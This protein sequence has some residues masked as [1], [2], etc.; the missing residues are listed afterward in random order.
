MNVP[1]KNWLEWLVFFI[2][3]GLVGATLSYLA[4]DALT[5]GDAP[6]RFEVRIG[7]P[8][9]RT[10]NF[11]VP[12]TIINHGDQTAEHVQVRVTLGNDGQEL[13]DATLDIELLPRHATRQGWAAF[14]ADPR[15]A[16]NISARVVGFTKP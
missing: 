8:E 1:Q 6:P 13:A 2:G 4:Y 3:L 15:K 7:A 5:L 11:I 16:Q 14:T 9:A 10:P 12:V